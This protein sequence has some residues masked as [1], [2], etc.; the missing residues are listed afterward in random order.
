[1]TPKKRKYVSIFLAF[2]F[3]IGFAAVLFLPYPKWLGTGS[4]TYTVK[5]SDGSVTEES[6]ADALSC[7]DGIAENGDILLKR[8][9]LFGTY[10]SD[11][12]VKEAISVLESGELA[13]MLSMSFPF[14]RLEAAALYHVYADLLY[15]DTGD[16]FRF[17]GERVVPTEIAKAQRV[18]FT[19]GEL[20]ASLLLLTEATTLTVGDLAEFSYKTIYGT[21]VTVEGKTRYIV[22]NNAIIDTRLGG[23]FIA[24]QPLATEIYV[25]DVPVA[26]RGA[27]LPCRELV[28]V[29]LPFVGSGPVAAGELYHGELGYLFT[30]GEEYYV[31]ASLKRVTVRG[32][33]LISFAFYHF[34]D[35]E[36]I[37]ACGV[38]PAPIERQAF[39]GLP[40]LK[41]LHTPRADVTL[42]D[43][44]KF[45]T[46]VAECGCTIYERKEG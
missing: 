28:S 11:F 18:F 43:P 13:P 34:P 38:D 37:D 19:G 22:E 31:P 10:V 2:L 12:C 23:T 5:W 4:D 30:E 8:D 27:L 42:T 15:F 3:G 35:L 36:E 39:E 14:N 20:P 40:S 33:A 16:W 26:A 21:S 45:T 29:D 6:Y 9:A 46:Y 1:M 7:L 24:G 41:R 25:P 44:E 17:D 32:G